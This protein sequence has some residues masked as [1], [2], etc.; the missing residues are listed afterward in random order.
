MK[1]WESEARSPDRPGEPCTAKQSPSTSTLLSCFYSRWG[2]WSVSKFG[3]CYSR[4]WKHLLIECRFS[5]SYSKYANFGCSNRHLCLSLRILKTV[6]WCK[7]IISPSL[8]QI[9]WVS[10]VLLPHQ[11]LMVSVYF[12]FHSYKAVVVSF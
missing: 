12:F 9:M 8:K 5:F 4:C 6:I 3:N 2:I 7:H 10:T 1:S 11:N